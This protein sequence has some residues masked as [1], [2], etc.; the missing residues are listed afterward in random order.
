MIICHC[1][2]VNGDSVVRAVDAG[3]RT[4]SQVCRSTGAGQD[5]GSCVFALRRLICEH[6]QTQRATLLEVEGAAS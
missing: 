1:G 3:A 5:C 2:V 4:L 6:E